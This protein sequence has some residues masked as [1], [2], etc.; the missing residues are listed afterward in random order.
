MGWGQHHDFG[1]ITYLTLAE[2]SI[3]Y[4]LVLPVFRRKI[5]I[6][7]YNLKFISAWTL[8]L[9]TMNFDFLFLLPLVKSQPSTRKD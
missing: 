3:L 9:D 5:S 7:C 1:K 6:P 4:F 8:K 2:V